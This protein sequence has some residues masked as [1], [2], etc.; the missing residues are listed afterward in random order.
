VSY[1]LPVTFTPHTTIHPQATASSSSSGS[2]S[3]SLTT[4]PRTKNKAY[5]Q[6]F[7]NLRQV[8]SGGFYKIYKPYIVYVVNLIKAEIKK[9]IEYD[10]FSFS[11][12][13]SMEP[14]VYD[15]CYPPLCIPFWSSCTVLFNL[16]LPCL[17]NW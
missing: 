4:V 1:H 11:T 14:I 3:S 2:T 8:L 13:P 17:P 9:D 5:M 16:L 12:L 6:A 10:P 7:A 15:V